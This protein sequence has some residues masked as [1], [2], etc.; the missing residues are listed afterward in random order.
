MD[1]CNVRSYGYLNVKFPATLIFSEYYVAGL[2]A[3][4]SEEA[5]QILTAFWSVSS[6]CPYHNTLQ[7]QSELFY[8]APIQC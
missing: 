5:L 3:E 6:P 4:P 7:I 1:G 2:Q 8:I